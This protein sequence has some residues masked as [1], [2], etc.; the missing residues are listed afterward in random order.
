MA[1][2]LFDAAAKMGHHGHDGA[3][4]DDFYDRLSRRYSVVLLIIFTILVS[5]K[6]YVG[7][8]IACF[9]PAHFTG[10]HVEYT[11]N[12]CWI[13]NTYFV[14]F[15]RIL[16]KD[17]DPETEHFIYFY[18]YVPFILI[19]Q[20]ILFY[21]PSLIWSSLN[22]KSGYDLGMLVTHARI[23][24]TYTAELRKTS[25]RH[26]ARFID[27]TLEYHRNK[28]LEYID[29]LRSVK[30]SSLSSI[31]SF[32]LLNNHIT[33]RDNHLMWSFL[34]SK[35]LYLLNAFGQLYLLNFFLG[36]DYHM[37]G[38]AVIRALFTGNNEN[39]TVTPRFPR[40]TWYV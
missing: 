37:Y 34:F 22:S 5:T 8:P 18:Q 12:V 35:L 11:N 7:E 25:V 33:M 32:F 30:C 14:S 1:A 23:I 9:C 31:Y 2:F 15:D 21:I 39:W 10:T 36:N 3:Y 16:P 19:V 29:Q 4:D 17:P 24:D 38:F 6:Q 40:V 28:R 27:K 13:S 26:L 20:A